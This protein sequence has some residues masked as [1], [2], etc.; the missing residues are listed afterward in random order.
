M[1]ILHAHYRYDPYG[2]GERYLHD[3]CAA[4]MQAGHTVSILTDAKM[5]G[6]SL[7]GE[8]IYGVEA[9]LGLRSGLRAQ[10]RVLEIVDA[11]APDIVHLHYTYWFLSPLIVQA[12]HA[13][14]PVLKTVHSLGLVCFHIG[15]ETDK[16]YKEAICQFPMGL[17]CVLR[18]CVSI[19][20]E[21][22]RKMLFCLWEMRVAKA[23]DKVVVGSQYVRQELLRNGFAANKIAILPLYTHKRAPV[24]LW[25]LSERVILFVGRLQETKG[26]MLLIAAL[27]LLK[28]KA[29]RAEIVGDGPLRQEAQAL[30]TRLGLE[31]RITLCGTLPPAQVD[32]H[33]QRAYLVVMPSLIPES[34]GL[35]GIEAMAFG[36]PVVAFAS[37]GITEWLVDQDTGLVV[38]RGNVGALAEKLGQLLDNP[39]LAQAM[40]ARGRERVERSYRPTTHLAR[41]GALYEEVIGQRRQTQVAP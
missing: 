5:C 15:Q 27:H 20:D 39:T 13:R 26:L 11:V 30:I 12:L 1:K 38:E 19:R 14:R 34:F 24:C 40:G 18:G 31:H 10:K 7:Y 3:L 28:D 36:K 29:W 4:Q 21:G 32:E 9:S 23:V 41:L 22:L 25:T 17:G 35:V 33:Y 37:G 2:G 16:M 6:G 8:P